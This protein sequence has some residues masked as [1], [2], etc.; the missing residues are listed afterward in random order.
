MKTILAPLDFSDP[1]DNALEYAA[2]IANNLKADLIL[3]HALLM[4]VASYEL[5]PVAF[6]IS[7]SI[8]LNETLLQERADKIKTLY[9]FLGSITCKVEMGDLKSNVDALIKSKNVDLI[10]LGVTGKTNNISKAIFGSNALSVSKNTEVPVI[11]VPLNCKYSGIKNIAY[12]CNYKE[13]L[14]GANDLSEIVSITKIFN[15]N[16]NVIHVIPEGHLLSESEVETD[17]YIESQL[18]KVVHRTFVFPRKNVVN[19]LID[20]IEKQK[21]DLIVM[22]Q[23]NHSFFHEIFYPSVTKEIAFSSPVP[24]MTVYI[25]Q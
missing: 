2:G 4:P 6:T 17:N 11:I 12:A 8:E 14:E 24:V 13:H 19:T 3:L 21:V 1:S 16:L 10:V 15:A 20:F 25:Q 9:P 22:E 7:N 18:E 23:V 5:E